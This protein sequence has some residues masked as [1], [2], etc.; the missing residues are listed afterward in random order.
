MSAP[1][2]GRESPDAP[3][4][5]APT[6]FE[7][8]VAIITGGGSGIGFGIASLLAELGA[9]VV[10]ASRS[11]DRLEGAVSE[12]SGKGCRADRQVV[13]VREPD[14]VR[15]L[16]YAVRAQYGRIDLLV[17]S[18]FFSQTGSASLKLS[19]PSGA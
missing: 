19:N 18:F 3:S 17:N 16:M 13:D 5:F 7:G 14:R 12:L 2:G 10:L 6:L 8:Q 11:A 1:A 9:Q 15:A 4:I